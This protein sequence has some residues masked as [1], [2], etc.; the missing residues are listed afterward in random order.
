LQRTVVVAAAVVLLIE[1]YVAVFKRDNDFI[2]HRNLGAAFLDGDPYANSGDWYPLPRVMLNGLIAAPPLRVARGASLLAAVGLLAWITAR[3]H[4]LG[5][6]RQTLPKN[7][8]FAAS[9]LALAVLLPY[10]LRDMDECGLQ[11]F[12]LAM[13]TAGGWALSRGRSVQ[14]G[15]WL[16]TAAVYKATPV[17]CLPYLL[18][19][20]RWAA[21][22]AMVVFLGVWAV[23][24]AAFLGW[25]KTVAAHRQ[26]LARNQIVAAHRTAYPELPEFEPPKA[27]NQSLFALVARYVETYPAGHPLNLEPHPLFRQF[28]S[29]DAESA[30]RVTRGVVLILGLVLAWQFRRSAAGPRGAGDF[31]AEWAA[32]CLLCALV[33]PW[34]WKQHLVVAL[35][36]A[37]LVARTAVSGDLTSRGSSARRRFAALAAIALVLLATRHSVVGRET[38]V[39]FLSYKIDTMLML[40]L[41]GLAL[42]TPV[43]AAL[44]RSSMQS[45]PIVAPKMSRRAA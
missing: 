30:Y 33:S 45:R 39:V 31:P 43:T 22:A 21:A 44:G 8:W 32:V 17:L 23:A 7:R 37:L 11:F 42:T 26:F 5:E 3:W 15:F 1:S 41:L 38:S 29:L 20:R 34:C 40:G 13:L 6:Q 18:W 10:I 19:K 4:Q 25:D 16:A 12:L 24:P 14:A 35:P 27:Q 28:G 36:A 2:F 9:A